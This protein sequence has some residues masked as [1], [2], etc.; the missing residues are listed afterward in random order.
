MNS[1]KRYENFEHGN[2]YYVASSPSNSVNKL[3]PGVYEL[4]LNPKTEQIYFKVTK[5]THDELV[6]LPSKAFSTVVGEIENFMRPETKGKFK[7]HGFVYKRSSLLHGKPGTGKTCIANRVSSA[8]VKM[9]GVVIQN[10]DPRLLAAAYDI[11]D[12]IQPET[13][14]LVVLE[15]MEK[16]AQRFEENLLNLLDGEIQKENVIY[17]GTTN[18][19]DKVP[20][21]LQRPGRFSSVIEVPFPQAPEREFFLRAKTDLRGEELK[22]WIKLTNGLS[23]DE[24]TECV[25]S[26]MCLGYQLEDVVKRFDKKAV[27]GT[28]DSEEDTE[29]DMD[30]E[31]EEAL[32]VLARNMQ[33]NRRR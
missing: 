26:V 4:V 31:L 13:L 2:G 30:Y 18:Y 25:R 24:V 11:L 19:I 12:H 27:E 14:V 32:Q 22:E 8:V 23:I 1:N 29:D 15:E 21:R 6:D 28:E 33:Q 16:L 5:N 10:P 9:G 3:P 17:I 20:K 7:Q